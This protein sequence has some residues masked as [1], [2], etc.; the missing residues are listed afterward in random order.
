MTSR[1]GPDWASIVSEFPDLPDA[2]VVGLAGVQNGDTVFTDGVIR[3]EF[4]SPGS[5]FVPPSMA[6]AWTR[7]AE[8]WFSAFATPDLLDGDVAIGSPDWP[9][10]DHP[11][12]WYTA[13]WF[14]PRGHRVT[15]IYTND[16]DLPFDAW[17]RGVPG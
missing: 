15:P 4:G 14:D 9:E 16:P 3:Y 1:Q 8:A 7:G 6:E 13:M 10:P 2:P 5:P 12:G 11:D 17:E